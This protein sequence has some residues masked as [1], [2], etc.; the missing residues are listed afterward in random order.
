MPQV[1]PSRQGLSGHV[2]VIRSYLFVGRKG[3][4]FFVDHL[5]GKKDYVSSQRAI[6]SRLPTEH[7]KGA[8]Y[9]HPLL[10]SR[11]LLSAFSAEP[12]RAFA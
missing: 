11:T 6:W 9:F 8:I 12:R 10:N 1:C 5:H 4:R 2:L 3:G 7:S